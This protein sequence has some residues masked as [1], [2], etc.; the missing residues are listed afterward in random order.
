MLASLVAG[1]LAVWVLSYWFTLA[2]GRERWSGEDH[3]WTREFNGLLL[4]RGGVGFGA[5]RGEW[6]EGGRL[7]NDLLNPT[8]RFEAAPFRTPVRSAAPDALLTRAGFQLL[9]GRK[10]LPGVWE[11]TWAV[12]PVW[13]LILL[14][15]GPAA[16]WFFRRE[17]RLRRASVGQCE[18]CGYDLRATPERCPECGSAASV[19]SGG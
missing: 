17:R 9:E 13:F 11:D 16:L 14:V 18:R 3:R 8:F 4:Y 7:G 1:M 2:V 15:A 6:T 10:T 12:A 19:T 5:S